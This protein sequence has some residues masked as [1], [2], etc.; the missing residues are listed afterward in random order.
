M[1]QSLFKKHNSDWFSGKQ[2]MLLKDV[3]NEKQEQIKKGETVILIG[4]TKYKTSFYIKSKTN[5]IIR[6]VPYYEL[7]LLSKIN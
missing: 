2:A 5:I 7:Q 1:Q 4:K 6:N 3:K